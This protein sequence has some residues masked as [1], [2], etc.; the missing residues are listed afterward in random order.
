MLRPRRNWTRGVAA[1]HASLSRWR[2]PVRIRS[3][4]PSPHLP[5]PRPPARTGRS[6]VRDAALR[7]SSVT[8]R[9]VTR[10]PGAGRRRSRARRARRRAGRLAA[11]AG[12]RASGCAR[13]AR[14]R[15]PRRPGDRATA[16][17][18]RRRRRHRPGIGDA[19]PRS[20]VAARRRR[21]PT[22]DVPIVPV[23]QVPLD[24]TSTD[25]EDVAAVL[26]G[27]G[28]RRYDAL[29]L[30]ESE[31]DAILA[32]LGVDRPPTRAHRH[33]RRTRR[34]LPRT[35]PRTASGSRSSAPSRR[36][37][38]PGARLGH[39]AL[40]GVDRVTD[41]GG[42]A[43]DRPRCRRA[44]AADAFD[45]ATTWTLFAGGDILL[46]RG[47]YLTLKTEGRRLPVRRRHRRDHRPLQGL[48]AAR[49][50][51]AVHASG[52]A[53][54]ARAR[55]DQGRRHRRS[56][57][58]RTRRPTSSASTPRARTS[59]PTRATSTAWRTPASTTSRSPTTTS[60]MRARP[61][62]SR[63]SGTST[64]RG[65]KRLGRGQGPRGGA[66]AGRSSRR[67]ARR[68]RS[69]ATTR[70]PAATTRRPPRSAAPAC[71]PR[72]S[73]RTWPRPQGGRRRRHRLPALGHRIRPDAR[74]P[75]SRSWPR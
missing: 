36:A 37:G 12:R 71:R 66:Q 11:G 48:L 59:R 7:R 30:V 4:P 53:T 40:F 32:A 55:P 51:H 70:S 61:G 72:P 52:P 3:G 63:R 13:R 20:T 22:A 62:S 68:S 64:K 16:T 42:L 73:R 49:L 15:G 23:D 75:T 27:D 41:L 9:R 57:T 38:G 74:S 1:Q 8:L 2:S 34:R 47:V 26:A 19:D 5:T 31:A 33:R 54:R 35:S 24:A 46:D 45:P 69:S 44:A 25:R 39:T 28:A 65:I 21:R 67:A 43:A 50:G 60:A 10:R 17:P 18:R 29:E 14:R 6:S 58:S 56:P